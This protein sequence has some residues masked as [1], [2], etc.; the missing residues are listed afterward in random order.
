MFR[1]L[2]TG[3]IK[4]LAV[5]SLKSDKKRN[6]FLILTI[7]FSACLMLTL[8]LKILGQ[9][10]KLNRYLKGRYQTVFTDLSAEKVE[11][12]KN[13]PEVE[14]SGVKV[15][16][17]TPR[18][19]DY[20][21][22]IEY[23]D[24][25]TASL[26]TY[27]E[28]EGSWP[29]TENEIIVESGCLEHLGLPIQT[30]QTRNMDMGDGVKRDYTVSG[31]MYTENE[32]RIYRV[33]VSEAYLNAVTDGNPRYTLNIRLRGTEGDDME[34]LKGKTL[35]LAEACGLKEQQVFYSSTY[36]TM[37]EDLPIEKVMAI[38]FCCLL[39]VVA[40][41]LVI[42]SLFY[43]SVVAKTQ[44]Y[45]RLRVIGTTRRQIKKLVRREGLFVSGIAIPVGILLGSLLGFLL[46]PE[47]WKWSISIP[48][49][50][51]IAVLT[52][53]AVMISIRTPLK[54]ASSVSPVEA[55]RINEVSTGGAVR[56]KERKQRR[57]TPVSLAFLNFGRN[58]RKAALTLCSL[59]F[60]GILLMCAASYLNSVDAD[61]M[62]RAGF[63]VGCVH[64]ELEQGDNGAQE[65][66]ADS[67]TE[68]YTKMEQDNPLDDE[69]FRELSQI[70]GVTDVAV[71]RG[72]KSNFIFPRMND[73]AR[74]NPDT[75]S[76]RNI[77][78]SRAQMEKYS[79]M[80]LEGT[81]DYDILVKEHGV[82]A[83]DSEKLMYRFYGYQPQLGDVIQVKTDQGTTVELKVMGLVESPHVGI[84]VPFFYVPDALLPLLKESVDNFNTHYMVE[85][86]PDKE[87][88]IEEAVIDMMED[89]DHV[90][91]NF[92]SD[93]RHQMV[94]S[95][96]QIKLPLYGLVV[97]IALFGILNLVNT[98][99]T[100]VVTRRQ[101]FGILQS[102]G[103]SGG[104]L[105]AMLK[106][107][108]FFYVAGTILITL[109]L[110]T[111]AG[112]TL[113]RIFDQLGTFGKLVF[114]FPFVPVFVFAALLLVIQMVFS[115]WA[116]RY[117]G[118]EPLIQRIKSE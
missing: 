17:G 63:G 91:I 111:A 101:E 60:T 108:C 76:F 26:L 80:L 34:T 69:M 97:F 19:R 28:L 32:A 92:L 54:I 40:T 35:A 105:S 48:C 5:N 4:R 1:N 18:I 98:L 31:V 23:V 110:G 75:L 13:R 51:V 90:E 6:L 79:D 52:E 27:G 95:M 7:A 71:F 47:G 24:A 55:V 62:A 9:N 85:G 14:R 30:G 84:D 43:I 11:E 86:E 67:A 83:G 74:E 16:L 94:K 39:I 25:E 113:C 70:D 41:S 45:G 77:G 96:E 66:D 10:T 73:Y 59:G 20:V 22:T 104:Q 64:I 2:N 78:L 57:I 68:Y 46:E 102:V 117:C 89:W 21:L 8:S 58:R 116:V 61:A 118:K 103:M 87:V 37:G 114:H 38:A 82:L 49:M 33:I 65:I 56:N 42:Y 112:W 81:I 107:E 29:E 106:A 115:V 72:C 36:F 50:A 99:L 88:Q 15:S 100:N 44:E 3:I 93:I 109:T 12:L 53:T